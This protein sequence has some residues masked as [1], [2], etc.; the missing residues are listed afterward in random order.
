VGSPATIRLST[1]SQIKI[2]GSTVFDGI[3]PTGG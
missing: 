1:S 2:D 3:D